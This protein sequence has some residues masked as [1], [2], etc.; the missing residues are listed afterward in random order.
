ME[1]GITT[2]ASSSESDAPDARIAVVTPDDNEL[3]LER[4]D[5]LVWIDEPGSETLSDPNYPVFGIG[6]CAITGDRYVEEIDQ[7]WRELKT[8]HFGGSDKLL[9]ASAVDRK[10]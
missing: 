2:L 6:G 10:N 3:V 4:T 9:H 5:L 8:A 1:P 7:P